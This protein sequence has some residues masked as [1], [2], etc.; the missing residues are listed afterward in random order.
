M[1]TK[2][3]IMKAA[4]LVK[5]NKPLLIS[6]VE[7]PHPGL[8][9]VLVK[10]S[11]SGI[12]GKQLDEINGT[13][14]DD[15]FLPH[16]LG[17]E[18]GGIVED[19]GPGVRKVKPGD[20][21]VL[22]WMKGSGIDSQT[23]KYK[24]NQ[25]YLNAGW[26]TTFSE[27][28]VVSENRVTPIPDDIELDVAALFGCAVT[29]GLGIVF[30]DAEIKPAESIAVFGIGGVGINV[31]QAA[32]LV[33][34]YPIVAIDRYD[35][36]LKMALEFGATHALN[37]N[38]GNIEKSLM[39]LSEERGFSV[40]VD[41][42]GNTDVF[43]AAYKVTAAAGKTILA[44]IVHHERPIKIDPFPF[45]S[46]RSIIGSHGGNTKPDIDIPRYVQLYK[47]GRL[48]IKEQ[49]THCFKL[50]DINNALEVVRKGEAGRC[51]ISMDNQT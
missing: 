45:H 4:V 32:A 48:K 42:T 26:V 29:T 2:N 15:A 21:V 38:N 33:N 47:L 28:T 5:Q 6:E 43:Q 37:S 31:I 46:G 30:N 17:H 51:V 23:P 27:Y 18:G 12:C 16:L 44:G 13:R 36:K 25:G 11:Y 3:K 34:A 24:W 35:N 7:I 41:T 49:I 40:T 39:E 20:H 9:Q 1:K 14:G 19:I 10:V 50:D 8:G 22:H